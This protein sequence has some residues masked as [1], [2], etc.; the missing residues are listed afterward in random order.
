MHLVNVKVLEWPGNSPDINPID[1]PWSI[2]KAGLLKTDCTTK[3][4][5]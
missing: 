5:G 2:I 3:K 4:T 1:N